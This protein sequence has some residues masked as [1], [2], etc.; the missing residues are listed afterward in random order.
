MRACSRMKAAIRAR[1]PA[2]VI[3]TPALNRVEIFVATS[4]FAKR[5]SF[6]K[7]SAR[8]AT[9]SERRCGNLASLRCS[10]AV[11]GASP[12]RVNGGRW[13]NGW[14]G[15]GRGAFGS[16]QC[17]KPADRS[18]AED[19][20]RLTARVIGGRVPKVFDR[21]ASLIMRIGVHLG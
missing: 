1:A 10:W 6:C 18:Q 7:R 13:L 4:A 19:K 14:C 5:N 20:R 3:Q 11:G 16:P 8:S 17:E 21:L 15:D 9:T 2:T 12:A